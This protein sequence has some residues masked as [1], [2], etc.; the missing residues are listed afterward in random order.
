MSTNSISL[1]K[2]V[3]PLTAY[4]IYM[5]A[6]CNLAC[7]HCW[8]APQ[9]LRNGGTGG[10]L[11]FDLYKL[12][13]EQGIP[14]GLNRVKYTGG[15]PLL[16]PDFVQ[17]VDFASEKQLA[18]LM[19]TNGT[20]M[21]REL[22][23]HL[24]ANTTM[25]FISVSLDGAQAETHDY[26]RN[27]PGSFDRAVRGISYLVEAGYRPQVIISLFQRNVH[28]IEDFVRWAVDAGCGSIKFNLIQDSGR[29]MQLK[30]NEGLT[31]P[32]LIEIGTW[33][34]KELQPQVPIRLAYSWPLAFQSLR[35]MND[36]H[37]N[38][39]G[40]FN[41]LGI[42]SNGYLAM[43]GI[44]TLEKDL[45][46]GR[47]GEDQC[48]APRFACVVTSQ[49][50]RNL[51]GLYPATSL[52]GSLRSAELLHCRAADGR[53]RVL[54]ASRRCWVVPGHSTAGTSDNLD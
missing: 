49:A 21:T 10:H 14:L 32:E 52:P 28:E 22:A 9:F 41:I 13:I 30:K 8:I 25:S 38:L 36:G 20:L 24:K 4:Y 50:R 16:H 40:I 6:G 42:L 17:M 45:V 54:P 39:C 23:R 19:E 15:E 1:P 12:A 53:Q 44:G 43:C 37:G 3:P 33:I 51:P 31:V 26:M 48:Y 5:T 7:R 27:V 35:E 46:Y 2:G 18:T 11:D 29:G 47:L 34:S